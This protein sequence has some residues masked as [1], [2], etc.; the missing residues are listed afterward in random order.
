MQVVGLVGSVEEG[1]S[2]YQKRALVEQLKV[3]FAAVAAALRKKKRKVDV[4]IPVFAH[5]GSHHP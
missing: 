5:L 2:R 4:T 3:A 1:V